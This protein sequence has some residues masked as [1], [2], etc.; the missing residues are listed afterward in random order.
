MANTSRKWLN[1]RFTL[2]TGALH[3]GHVCQPPFH[4]VSEWR[5]LAERYV[6]VANFELVELIQ[7]TVT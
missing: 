3:E 5:P 6:S 2:F 4:P 1:E 7:S